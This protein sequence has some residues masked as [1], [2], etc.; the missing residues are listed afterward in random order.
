MTQGVD[1]LRDAGQRERKHARA[2]LVQDDLGG[3]R[4]LPRARRFR[5]PPYD[6]PE[7]LEDA[8]K[9][10]DAGLVVRVFDAAADL[11]ELVRAHRGIAHE[12][13]LPVGPIGAH[14][15]ECGEALVAPPAVVAPH[16]VVDAVVEVEVLEM[17]ELG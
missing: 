17:A 1:A 9:P 8:R 14:E 12:Y 10:R 15:L 4:V 5:I 2:E 3:T 6:A 16:V 7:V 11:R 13:D